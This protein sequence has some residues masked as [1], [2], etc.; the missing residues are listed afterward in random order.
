MPFIIDNTIT[1][2]KMWGK[3]ININNN[4]YF[5]ELYIKLHLI[6]VG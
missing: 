2:N 3:K 4:Y 6:I 5:F 1:L